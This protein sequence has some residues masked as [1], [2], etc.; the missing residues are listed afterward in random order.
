MLKRFPFP[1]AGL[2]LSLAALGNLLQSYGDGIRYIFGGI[3]LVLLIILILKTII[4]FDVFLEEMKKPIIASVMPSSSMTIMLLAGYLKPFYSNFANILWY[5]GVILHMIFILYFTMQFVFKFN[6]ETLFPSWFITFVGIVVASVTGKAFNITIGQLAFYFGLI[7]YFILLVL[8]VVRLKKFKLN[9]PELPLTAILAAP[10]SLCLAGYLSI[11]ENKNLYFVIGLM[12]LSQL[13]YLYVIKEMISI[14]KN[15]KVNFY[16]S[17][18]GF[19]FPLVITAISLKLANGFFI[20]NG[21][22]MVFFKYAVLIETIIA[23]VIV[24][25]VLI[26]YLIFIF[27][28][29]KAI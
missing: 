21:K 12:I 20:S 25:Y 18:S 26:K 2:I 17:Y 3:S 1:I 9:E 4:Y 8:M 23:V 7:A 27:K 15:R 10:G 22:N 29:E 11:F 5:L 14:F 16:P 24:I 19:T 28:R 13:I 6:I